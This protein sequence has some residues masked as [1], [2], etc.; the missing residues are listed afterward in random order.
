MRKLFLLI[1]PVFIWA[2]RDIQEKNITR[3]TV[4]LVS[5]RDNFSSSVQFQTFFWSKVDGASAYRIQ[6]ATPSFAPDSMTLLVDS[7]TKSTQYSISLASGKK[8]QWR[9]AAVN[10]AYETVFAAPRSLSI[11]LSG[12]VS[13]QIVQLKSPNETPFTST[14]GPIKFEWESV[15]AADHYELGFDTI[16]TNASVA[17]NKTVATTSALASF[18]AE[19]KYIWKVKAI[20]K[21]GKS[22]AYSS[23][24]IIVDKTKPTVTLLLP[25]AKYETSLDSV[26]FEWKSEDVYGLADQQLFVYTDSVTKK[27]YNGYP[28]TI[29]TSK[30]VLRGLTPAQKLWWQVVT[31]DKATN[32]QE[33]EL[34]RFARK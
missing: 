33:S 21:T 14:L 1:L 12:D 30:A 34:R 10:S 16:L 11:N 9:V 25:S 27:L 32:V 13:I 15:G 3:S 19:G 22:S 24:S 7:T 8:Y 26:A 31:T 18:K 23:R 2:C 20:D 4:E 5:P 28:Q 6:I 17:P 29:G